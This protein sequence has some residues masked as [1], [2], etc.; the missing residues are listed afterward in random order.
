MMYALVALAVI[1]AVVAC[2][3]AAW[4]IMV[5]M[6]GESFRG[7]FT[8]A[9]EE[10]LLRETLREQLTVLAG[11]IG[12]RHLSGRC[13]QLSE[14]AEFIE[15]ILV[16]YGYQPRRHE[17]A[18]HGKT[19]WNIEVERTGQGRPGEIL[20]VGAH[21]DTV[22]GSPGANDN[23]TAVVANLALARAFADVV[24]ERTVRFAF[25]V[26]EESPWHMTQDMGALRY[27]QAC[28]SRGE[29]VIGMIS[30]EMVGCYFDGTGSQRYPADLLTWF[31][32]AQGNFLAVVGNIASRRWLHEFVGALRRTEFPVEGMA[33]PR[34]LKDV[35][36]SDHAAFWHCGY[37]AVMVT[38][39]ANFRYPYYHTAEDTIDKI[40]FDAMAR[41]ATALRDA[42]RRT[43]GA[44][45]ER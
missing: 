31:Y 24:A 7:T 35:F 8:L 2:G 5:W 45:A 6:P 18:V 4:R 42:L 20:I 11:D 40:N 19:V 14:A 38:D 27:A 10:R 22:P 33:A 21:Y 41:A 36:R 13:A 39:T 37:P 34:W 3:L 32:P 30:L 28:R 43:A 23:G 25:F 16:S 17:F 1:F 44:G 9:D 12:E 15:R 26:N 29:R